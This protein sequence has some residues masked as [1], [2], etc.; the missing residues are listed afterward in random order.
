MNDTSIFIKNAG[1]SV[2]FKK[3]AKSRKLKI[4]KIVMAIEVKII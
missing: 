3:Y 2:D 4:Q 1:G